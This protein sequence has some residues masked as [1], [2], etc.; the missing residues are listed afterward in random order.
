MATLKKV[1]ISFKGGLGSESFHV[2]EDGK[3]LILKRTGCYTLGEIPRIDDDAI[4]A[5]V[6]KERKLKV[7]KV[8]RV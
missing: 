3:K 1:E 5:L 2:E 8:K 6:E 4:V 7:T